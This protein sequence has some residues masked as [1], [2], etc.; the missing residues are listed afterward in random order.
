MVP[1]CIG[2]RW[3]GRFRAS[4]FAALILVFS[5]CD[6]TES[7]DPSSSL[8][9]D[10]ADQIAVGDLPADEDPSN[11]Q[12][13]PVGEPA[14][15]SASFA[16]GIPIGMAGQPTSAFGSRFNGGK[17]TIGAN[18][19]LSQ[20]SAIRARGGR[21]VVMFAGNPRH[22]QDGNNHF[23]LSKWKAR[24]DLFKKLNFSS[25]VSDGTIIGHFLLDEPNDPRNWGGQQ[26]SPSVVEQMA[27]YS[28]QLWPSLATIVRVEPGYLSSNHRYLDAAWAQYLYRRGNVNDY[29]KRNVDDAQKRGL[30]LVVGLNVLKGGN[31]N[32]SKMSASEVESWGSALLSSSYPC[33]FV[34]WQYNSDYLSSAGIGGAMVALRRKAQSR[35]TMCGR[36]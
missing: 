5:G 1:S 29:I 17:L 24:V 18:Q 11:V 8:T 12:L 31:P 6:S 21:A 26:V 20:L 14:V 15:A 28:K 25:Y 10:A 33:A 9:P 35:S 36:G 27:Q 32:G 23:S 7:L 13:V 2:S 4:V 30:G 34:M 22:Y 3:I 19:L 16:G